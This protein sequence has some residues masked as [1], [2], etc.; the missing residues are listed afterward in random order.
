[1]TTDESDYEYE[2]DQEYIYEEEDEEDVEDDKQTSTENFSAGPSSSSE[3]KED[4]SAKRKSFT[5][6]KNSLLRQT[7][8]SFE[9]VVP[10]DS[11]V[12]RSATEIKP[13]FDALVAEVS[14]LLG[15]SE[16]ESQALL[17][18]YKWN[19]EKL[20]NN[21]FSDSEKVRVDLGL[22]LFS[23]DIISRL[24]SPLKCGEKFLCRVCYDEFD[25][26]I[27]VHLGC[28]HAFCRECFSKYL[29]TQIN[30][31]P[32]CILARCPEFKCK[33]LITK[34][35]VH[36]LLSPEDIAK[37]DSYFLRNFIETSKSMKY[38]PA[39][40]CDKV[41]VGSGITSVRCDCG[42]PFCFRCGEEA[43]DPCSCAQLA[44]WMEKCSNESET[45]NWILANTR[46]CP[47]C[48]TRIE[49]NHGCNHMTCK[50]CKHE[51]CWICMGKF[52][53]L[54]IFPSEKIEV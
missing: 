2:D 22:D 4:S 31:G 24:H 12:I 44:E 26:G 23:T 3:A 30:D 53:L 46:K 27:S 34:G 49:K 13:L 40:R 37:Y 54:F 48:Q 21:Y 19:K 16:E 11:Y 36:T 38:C 51:F 18:Y 47:S 9:L 45:A 39:P 50:V 32:A 7:S 14:I 10:Y 41:A 25:I 17:Q 42:Y 8:N 6:Q 43:H 20:N 15:I 5:P 33:Q 35:I 28:N 29:S 52:G 1:M